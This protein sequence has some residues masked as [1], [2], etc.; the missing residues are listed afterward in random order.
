MDV[1]NLATHTA[2]KL[3]ASGPDLRIVLLEDACCK[4]DIILHSSAITS[5][6]DLKGRKVAYDRH[7]QI[8]DCD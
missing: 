4:A 2:L 1:A 3:Y 6:A 7:N 8:G 5:I